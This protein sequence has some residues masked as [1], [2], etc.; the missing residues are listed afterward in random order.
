MESMRVPSQGSLEKD[1]SLG[2]RRRL[3]RRGAPGSAALA[4]NFHKGASCLLKRWPPSSPLR[5]H[6]ESHPAGDIVT[7]SEWDRLRVGDRVLVHDDLSTVDDSPLYPGVVAT[8]DRTTRSHAVGIRVA[9]FSGAATP[10]CTFS[11]C[12]FTESPA[13]RLSPAGDVT[14]GR[15]R[16]DHPASRRWRPSGSRVRTTEEGTVVAPVSRALTRNILLVL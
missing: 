9:T 2:K 15:G 12:R 1:A 14:G 13:T 11:G 4:E 3:T 16:G 7:A 8:V 5:P 6:P 10:I